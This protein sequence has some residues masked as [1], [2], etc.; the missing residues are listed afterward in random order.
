MTTEGKS[1]GC[2]CTAVRYRVEGPLQQITACHCGQCRKIT[3]HFFASTDALEAD[4]T[5]ECPEGTLT[6]YKS[7]DIA[8]RGFC[9]RCGSCL[10]W[11]KFDSGRI[12]ITPGTLDDT[13]SLTIERH[14]FCKWKGD[15]YEIPEGAPAF[16]EGR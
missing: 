10:F 16:E 15:Y 6:W 3:G 12:A 11:R 13:K 8:E 1:G 7:S 4:T 2:L 5:I 14:I 9:N